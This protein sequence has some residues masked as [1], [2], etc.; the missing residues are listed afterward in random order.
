[1]DDDPA[2]IGRKV[3]E[4][5]PQDA[6]KFASEAVAVILIGEVLKMLVEKGLL[7]EGEVITTL[8]KVSAEYM[9]SPTGEAAGKAVGFLN[10]VRDIVAGEVNRK[11]S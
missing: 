9:V 6:A 8:E 3:A 11:P 2:E 4:A 5:N 1:M 7:N 10:I